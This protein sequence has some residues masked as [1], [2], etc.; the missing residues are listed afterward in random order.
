MILTTFRRL[1]ERLGRSEIS[2]PQLAPRTATIPRASS[3][4]DLNLPGSSFHKGSVPCSLQI[5]QLAQRH[6]CSS[7][8]PGEFGAFK[9]TYVYILFFNYLSHV[10]M[11]NYPEALK[12]L[13]ESEMPKVAAERV[14]GNGNLAD[15]HSPL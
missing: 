4:L 15:T 3:L 7:H 12:G 6:Y 5:L 13:T 14:A 8:P 11:L 9:R 2:G 1:E 10:C